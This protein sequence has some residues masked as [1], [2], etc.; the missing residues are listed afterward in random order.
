MGEA[1]MNNLMLK[2]YVSAKV[3]LASDVGQD[4]PEYA[5]AVAVIAFG[6]V[7]G[8]SSLAGG[9][10]QVFGDVSNTLSTSI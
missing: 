6:C 5:L 10:N 3:L 8:M 1:E 7:A 4:L 2:L 9:I